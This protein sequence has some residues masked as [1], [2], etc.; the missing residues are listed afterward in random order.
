MYLVTVTSRPVLGYHQ[1]SLHY[2]SLTFLRKIHSSHFFICQFNSQIGYFLYIF[3]LFRQ[4][5]QYYIIARQINR[6]LFPCYT[7][8]LRSIS[9]IK[10]I[11]IIMFKIIINTV[12]CQKLCESCNNN[13]MLRSAAN[14]RGVLRVIAMPFLQQFTDS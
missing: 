5:N 14:V 10:L 12:S 7:F 6:I 2:P 11:R 1:L 9:R 3:Q 8:N 4:C 13:V